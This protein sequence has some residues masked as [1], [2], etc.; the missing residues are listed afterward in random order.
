MI[1]NSA[2]LLSEIPK[3]NPLSLDYLNFWK[4]EKQKIFEG[5]WVGGK[6]MPGP[7]YMYINFWTIL[8]NKSLNSKAKTAGRPFLRDLEWEKGYI[9]ME[10]R[11]FSGF[12][13]DKVYTCDRNY[14]P[15]V[16]EKNISY[17][18]IDP[19]DS[20]IYVPA[21]DYLRKIHNGNLGKPLF[22]NQA[23]NII[24]IESR[25]G[26][27]SYFASC[28]IAHNFITDGAWDYE[29]HL[30]RRMS[31]KEQYSSETLVG[32]I[33]A[34]YSKDLLSKFK[35]G[36]D[37]LPGSIEHNGKRYPSPLYKEYA[38]SLEPSKYWEAKYQVKM[39]NNWVD[40]GSRSKIHHRTFQDN[41]FAANG[42]RPGLVLLEEVGFMGNLID[43]L[44]AIKECTADGANQFGTTWMFGTGGDMAGG[45]TFAA[46]SVFYSP[47]DYNCL[48]FPDL[49]ENRANPIGFFVPAVKTLNQ[50]KDAEGNTNEER[51][52]EYLLGER[53]KAK[54]SKRV[55]NLN[56]ELQNRPITHSEAFLVTGV[57]KFPV[58]MLKERLAEVE[59]NP[60]K[61]LDAHWVGNFVYDEAMFKYEFV[62]KDD[63]RPIREFPL[64]G[65][66]DAEG[67]IELFEKPQ[68]DA[69]GGVPRGIYIAGIDPF[70]DDYSSTNSLGS[71]FIFNRLT[72]RI[73]AEYTGRPERAVQFYENCRKLLM[74]YNAVALYEN[75]WKGLFTHFS[76]MKCTHLLADTPV[77]L[78][79]KE[80]WQENTNK[81][82]GVPGTAAVN[83]F[84]RSLIK[85]WLL[86]PSP[87]NP[88]ILNLYRIRS[89]GLLKEL[90]THNPDDNF[91]RVSSLGMCLIYDS[92]FVREI[93]E[94]TRK[95]DS[96]LTS[97]YFKNLGMVRKKSY[98]EATLEREDISNR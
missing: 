11:G 22:E 85:D 44:G 39:G 96:F 61:Y 75:N 46:Q 94:E 80:S 97:D 30:E 23:K 25:G 36:Y 53:Q 79:D 92:E 73:V 38:G 50:F 7:L 51:A 95:K 18:L 65:N 66:K 43:S 57:N 19:N 28:C 13:E 60:G 8:L 70:D 9:Y 52:L 76:Q 40:R 64:D 26:G 15:E 4:E 14:A 24:D 91:D 81:S 10:A 59:G 16:R 69:T 33:D 42:T 34:K 55:E 83:A 98:Q 88:E 87:T 45:A 63:A 68:T 54:E 78:R 35:F 93:K 62:V 48:M 31:E 29:D 37:E 5:Y 41:P 1:S 49:W 86:E 47:N 89:L 27:K 84:A 3:F 77:S 2:F 56:N 21:R 74:Y 72:R 90:I 32:A 82:K 6:W 71:I 67:A 17:G 58:S 20:R 12:S